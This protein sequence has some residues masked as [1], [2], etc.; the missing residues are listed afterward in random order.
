MKLDTLNVITSATGMEVSDVA[1]AEMLVDTI[2]NLV[3]EPSENEELS[4]IGIEFT[5]QVTDS[6]KVSV[7]LGSN[8]VRV[9][10]KKRITLN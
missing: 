10:Q 4:D 5:N 1:G 3:G 7:Y 9:A 2:K 6:V 8:L